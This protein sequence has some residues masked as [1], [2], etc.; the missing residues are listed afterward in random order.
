MINEMTGPD[1]EQIAREEGLIKLREEI[2]SSNLSEEAKKSLQDSIY[3]NPVFDPYIDAAQDRGLLL[4][5]DTDKNGHKRAVIVDEHHKVGHWALIDIP[6][7]KSGEGHMLV[8]GTNESYEEDRSTGDLTEREVLEVRKAYSEE[9]SDVRFG[10]F[11][12]N[13]LDELTK[14]A[15]E[16][17]KSLHE[18]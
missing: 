3:A 16:E 5:E 11:S 13:K 1:K 4:F 8:G 12:Q 10:E 17:N 15:E 18:N 7:M 6:E 2:D 14:K 9:D